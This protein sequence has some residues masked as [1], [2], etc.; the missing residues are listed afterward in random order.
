MK[1]FNEIYEEI[2]NKNVGELELL[3]KAKIKKF[4]I[5][6]IIAIIVILLTTRGVAVYVPYTLIIVMMILVFNMAF[7]NG[8][9]K[10][11]FKET[12]IATFI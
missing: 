2:Y 12:V 5:A 10:N 11:K 3:R 4:A 7:G 9:Y 1:S 6:I 8:K